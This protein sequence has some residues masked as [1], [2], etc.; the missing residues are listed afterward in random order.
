MWPNMIILL[1]LKLASSVTAT[2]AVTESSSYC[3]FNGKTYLTE[4]LLVDNCLNLICV[5]D[6]WYPT[7]YASSTCS[8]CSLRNDPHFTGFSGLTYDFHGILEYYIAM[9]IDTYGVT[10]DFYQ[11]NALASCLDIITYKD[12]VD[13]MITF[14]KDDGNTILVNGDP[15]TVTNVV[16]NVESADGVVHPVLAWKQGLC[17][18]VVGTRGIALSFC[19]HDMYVWAE[20]AILGDLD[21]LCFGGRAFGAANPK[22]NFQKLPVSQQQINEWGESLLVSGNIIGPLETTTAVSIPGTCDAETEQDL[23]L[24]C[25][26]LFSDMSFS[27]ISLSHDLYQ[28]AVGFCAVDLCLMTLSNATQTEIEAW[29]STMV[30]MLENT[31]EVIAFTLPYR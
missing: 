16:Q 29:K 24:Q 17:I 3:I 11:C 8:M 26:D 31:M 12:G 21:G 4:E 28:T 10:G 14:D 15:F 20:N 18:R 9:N 7:G 25:L 23:L 1:L 6:T 5:G 22:R 13:T 27:Q 2:T 19:I 30:G